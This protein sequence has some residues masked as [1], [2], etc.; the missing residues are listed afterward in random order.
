MNTFSQE[1]TNLFDFRYVFGPRGMSSAELVLIDKLDFEQQNLYILTLLAI[2]RA[3]L[4]LYR[5]CN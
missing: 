5:L 1:N 4:F 3:Y 2:V